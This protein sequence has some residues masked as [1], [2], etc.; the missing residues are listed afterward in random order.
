[1]KI[2]IDGDMFA[3]RACSSSEKEIEWEEGMFT[4]ISDLADAKSKF[5]LLLTHCLDFLQARKLYKKNKD[6]VII[7]FSSKENFRKTITPVY[8]ANRVK[9]KPLGYYALIDYIQ[10][11]YDCVSYPKLEADDC[12][13]ILATQGEQAV[14][15]SGDKDMKTIPCLFYDFLHDELIEVDKDTAI[16][17]HLLQT[18]VGDA[19]DNYKGCPSYGQVKAKRYLDKAGYTWE[20]VCKAF[21]NAGLSEDIALINAQLAHILQDGDYNFVTGEIKVWKPQKE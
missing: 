18:L 8:K 6:E 12:I 9:R 17:N 1:M 14:I 4:L 15:I 3:F 20:A 11:E 13:G 5:I 21:A 7:C 16:K 19:S 10:K 2:L